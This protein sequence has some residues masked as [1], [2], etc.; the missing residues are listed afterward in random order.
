MEQLNNR[1]KNLPILKYSI[2]PIL[3]IFSSSSD[4][5]KVELGKYTIG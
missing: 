4:P 5:V 3:Q 1:V 2:T